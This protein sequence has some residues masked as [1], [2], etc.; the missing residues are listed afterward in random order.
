MS[1]RNVGRQRHSL[2]A[3]LGGLLRRRRN[4]YGFLPKP[5]PEDILMKV[6]ENATHVPSAGFT[7][8]FDF[9]VVRDVATKKKIA[10]AAMEDE[11]VRQGVAMRG[12]ISAAPVVIVPCGNKPRFEAKYGKPAEK[13]ARLPWWLIDA[14]FASLALILSAFEEGLAASFVGAVDDDRIVSALGLPRN[15]SVMPLAVIPIGYRDPSEKPAWKSK[16]RSKG[17]IPRRP[18]A[19][20]VHWDKW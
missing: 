3:N 5:I 1:T 7:Q 4:V 11:Y 6:L 16:R 14:G 20:V 9:V 15:G 18:L 2:D 10:A 12:F 19:E 8:D 13:N 17:R